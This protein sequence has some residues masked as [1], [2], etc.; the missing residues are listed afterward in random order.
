MFRVYKGTDRLFIYEL[1]DDKMSLK[2]SD[3]LKP[4]EGIFTYLAKNDDFS[5]KWTHQ[6]NIL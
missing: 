1:I 6:K 5:P 3:V 4:G 2:I